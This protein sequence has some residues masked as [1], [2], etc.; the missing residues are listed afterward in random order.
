M[1]DSIARRSAW[2]PECCRR[3]SSNGGDDGNRRSDGRKESQRARPYRRGKTVRGQDGLHGPGGAF[4]GQEELCPDAQPGQ[5]DCAWADCRRSHRGRVQGPQGDER[6]ARKAQ[7][8]HRGQGRTGRQ[9]TQ[10]EAQARR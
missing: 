4:L 1:T 6:Q 9:G 7:D 8:S 2:K 3:W 5:E 10:G